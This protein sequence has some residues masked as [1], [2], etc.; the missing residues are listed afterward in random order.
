ME[1]VFVTGYDRYAIEAFELFAFD[2]L[3]KPLRLPRLKKTVE[4][5]QQR[6]NENTG[7]QKEGVMLRCFGPLTIQAPGQERKSIKWR[8]A[9]AQELFAFLL[10]HHGKYIERGTLLDL[11]WPDF[12]AERALQQ[13]YTTV[14]HIRQAL[15]QAGLTEIVI[16][17]GR[18]LGGSYR[19]EL[20][21]DMTIDYLEWEEQLKQ[22]IEPDPQTIKHFEKLLSAYEEDYLGV[23]DYMWAE[24]KREKLRRLWRHYYEKVMGYYEEIG[25]YESAII[26]AERMQ[27]LFPLEEDSYFELMKYYDAIGSKTAVEDQYYLLLSRFKR[28]LEVQ[29]SE[30]IQLWYERWKQKK[31]KIKTK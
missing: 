2:Y 6:L 7:Q 17:S 13:L 11:L 10:H 20:G 29:P 12:D 26:L 25:D 4:R 23:Y 19:L 24:A 22:L 31:A 21:E 9:K 30:V 8:T 5:L 1:I 14:Y 27:E 18:E 3:L 16:K 15:Q 28:E